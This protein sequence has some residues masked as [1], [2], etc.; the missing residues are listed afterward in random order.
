MKPDH[1]DEIARG[2][3]EYPYPGR[4]AKTTSGCGLPGQRTSKK[5]IERVRPGVELVFAIF[6]PSRELITLDLPTFER[7]RNATSGTAGAGKC[8][9]LTAEVMNFERT[10]TTQFRVFGK[11]L[12]VAK[13]GTAGRKLNPAPA[14]A[15][16]PRL[17]RGPDGICSA[18]IECRQ[19]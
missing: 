1:W 16:C 9:T 13:G 19:R 17:R 8:S 3:R 11:N 12:Q 7:P 5:L 10:R 4:S 14:G 18:N 15:Y 2:T 6:A